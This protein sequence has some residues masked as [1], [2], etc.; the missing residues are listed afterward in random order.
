MGK[1]IDR[2]GMRYGQLLV[3]ADAG[4]GLSKKRFWCCVCDCGKE[5]TV[6]ANS[7]VTGNTRSC[8]CFHLKQI[9]KHGGWKRSSYNTWRA[10]LRRC[11]NPKDKDYPR[12]GARG[13]TVC[14][15]WEDYRV[16][17]AD[18][19][20]PEGEQTLDRVDNSKGYSKENCRWASPHVQAINS[21]RP[22]KTG[23]RG[24]V[25]LSKYKKWMASITVHKKRY[26]SVVF[27]SVEGAVTARKQ[28]EERHWGS[29]R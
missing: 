12:Y 1:F 11:N 15:E 24:V 27:D 29:Q 3:V 2:T 20:E 13:I 6:S 14:S 18:M 8:G 9:T 23:H 7:L 5:V 21:K 25:Y 16:F 28:L 26:Y 22:S 4:I 19:G 17:A 10:M